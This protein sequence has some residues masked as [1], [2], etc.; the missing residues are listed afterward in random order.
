MFLS[1]L[2]PGARQLRTP[3]AIGYL[4]LLVAWINAPHVPKK[5]DKARL[6]HRTFLEF[7]HVSP[8]IALLAIS[9]LAYLIGMFFEVFDDFVLKFAVG[10]SGVALLTMFPFLALLILID[11]P[12]ALIAPAL[13]VLLIGYARAKRRKTTTKQELYQWA[14][15]V[16][17]LLRTY[18]EMVRDLILRIWSP[19]KPVKDELIAGQVSKLL[20]AHPDMVDKFCKTL[21][22]L[23][24]RQAS[25][26]A[27]LERNRSSKYMMDTDGQV[28]DVAKAASRSA[29]DAGSEKILRKYLHD[30]MNVSP[31]VRRDIV[32]SVLEVSDIRALV[33]NALDAA[34]THIQADRPRVF[35]SY[36]R[37]RTEGEFRRGIAVP[38]G[39]ALGSI[40][41]LYSHKM[42][43]IAL[44]LL[45]VI[46][47]YFSGMKKQEE[48]VKV[49]VD[50]VGA[51][52]TPI[53]L[54]ISD[55]MLLRWPV[56]KEHFS[57]PSGFT[58]LRA[59]LNRWRSRVERDVVAPN[60]VLDPR[61]LLQIEKLRGE[62]GEEE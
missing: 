48:A 45:P 31:A 17:V 47:I 60:T 50:S 24:L 43:L 8:G 51:Q 56:Q 29:I 35:E 38:M 34:V 27:G 20:E 52:I 19:A 33:N 5:F 10:A 36:D 57:L 42:E 25:I 44:S 3:L 49:V 26:A 30:R 21:S 18:W 13:I 23:G 28:V 11:R 9:F 62:V 46:V 41:V 6:I 7:P 1:D 61:S 55:A 12:Y 39:V 14:E 15:N 54:E 53:R 58:K 4:W 32:S 16:Y 2:L 37:L 59:R 22:I 40:C